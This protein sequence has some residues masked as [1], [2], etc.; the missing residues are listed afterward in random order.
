MEASNLVKELR[1]CPSL[2]SIESGDE[3]EEDEDENHG[4]INIWEQSD[5]L[6]N[7]PLAATTLNFAEISLPSQYLINFLLHPEHCPN[8]QSLNLN[9]FY[10]NREEEGRELQRTK[11]KVQR[12]RDLCW[13]RGI[14]VGWQTF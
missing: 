10:G 1:L 13:G 6:G 2:R 14:R 8:L 7:L 12:I 3:G 11:S 4:E 5:L 9:M